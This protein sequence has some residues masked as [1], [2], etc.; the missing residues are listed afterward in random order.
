M[1]TAYN[2]CPSCG[3][4]IIMKFPG[5]KASESKR[6]LQRYIDDGLVCD[7]CLEKKRKAEKQSA[8]EFS[9]NNDLPELLGTEKQINWALQIR[10]QRLQT[11]TLDWFKKNENFLFYDKEVS[12]SRLDI[13]KSFL[14]LLKREVNASQWIDKRNEID[15]VFFNNYLPSAISLIKDQD[16]DQEPEAKEVFEESTI[17]PDEPI[18]SDIVEVIVDSHLNQIKIVF[19]YRF[20]PL[21][22]IMHQLFFIWDGSSWVLKCNVIH[23]D[24]LDRAAETVYQL[25]ANGMIALCLNSE[26]REKAQNGSFEPRYPRW[27]VKEGEQFAIYWHDDN[28][29]LYAEI[30][31]L[32]LSKN[33]TRYNQKKWLVPCNYLDEIESMIERHLI[34]VSPGAENLIT[35]T[36]EKHERQL[37]KRDLPSKNKLNV[38]SIEPDLPGFGVD[39]SLKDD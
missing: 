8:I 21:T 9:K 4:Q 24:F 34:K 27:L 5:V 17:R 3:N 20:K 29:A 6:R 2:E 28:R 33:E 37:L 38:K 10:H 22:E 7:D 1:S 25:L 11:F 12:E 19:P 32:K 26:V 16:K 39:E 23:G 13:F 15:Q 31:N 36:R 14:K 18:N 35:M 30:K